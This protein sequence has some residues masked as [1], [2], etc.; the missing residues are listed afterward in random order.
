MKITFKEKSF[1][2]E[3]IEVLDESRQL[4][5]NFNKKKGD[6]YLC[7]NDIEYFVIA[8]GSLNYKSELINVKN[9]EKIGIINTTS[10]WSVSFKYNDKKYI[11]VEQFPLG[12]NFNIKD[13]NNKIILIGSKNLITNN[14]EISSLEEVDIFLILYTFI[15][16]LNRKKLLLEKFI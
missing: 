11:Y 12:Y 2:D 15:I 6:Y 10:K 1:F 5:A 8:D 16:K 9:K 4:I 14:A 7:F 3:N 13:G